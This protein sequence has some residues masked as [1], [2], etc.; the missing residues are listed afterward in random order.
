MKYGE[1]VFDMTRENHPTGSRSNY[2]LKRWKKYTIYAK[3]GSWNRTDNPTCNL[4]STSS[5]YLYDYVIVSDNFYSSLVYTASIVD[6]TPSNRA[7]EVFPNQWQH[8]AYTFRN[9]PNAK[10]NNYQLTLNVAS[11]SFFGRPVYGP[12]IIHTAMEE[13]FEIAGS[14][15]TNHF[16]HKRPIFSL[17]NLTTY[18]KD[19]YGNTTSGSY[20]R[21]Q[22]TIATTIGSNG[23]EDGSPP[24]QTTQ[25][26][27]LN[28]VQSN[29]VI[30]I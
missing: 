27:V 12:P 9:S 15:P 2:W 13:Y 20:R 14:Y 19:S 11:S 16:T 23:L 21:C 6:N 5:V 3:S 22:Q 26:S 29:N 7:D 17:Y 30:N 28:L 10:K 25:V 18:G 8:Q 4:Y 1:I 24:F